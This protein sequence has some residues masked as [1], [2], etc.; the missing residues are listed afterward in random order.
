M[1]DDNW[2]KLG[3]NQ[4][5]NPGHEQYRERNRDEKEEKAIKRTRTRM[6]KFIQGISTFHPSKYQNYFHYLS[7]KKIYLGP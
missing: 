6:T 7:L 4:T 2:I 5:G 1:H 3:E